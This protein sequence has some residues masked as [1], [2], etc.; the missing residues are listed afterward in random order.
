MRPEEP[1]SAKAV[2]AVL[3]AGFVAGTS[4]LLVTG[5]QLLTASTGT[6]EEEASRGEQKSSDVAYHFAMESA[7]EPVSGAQ[8]TQTVQTPLAMLE[9]DE[10]IRITSE[11]Q[12]AEW[13]QLQEDFVRAV[14]GR[15]P[16]NETEREA[17]IRAQQEND[18]LFR[19]KFGWDAFQQQQL[20]AHRE[21]LAPAPPP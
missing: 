8:D 16:S 1:K 4:I 18:E 15:A 12:V 14:D 7:Q 20:K 5:N 11:L 2:W 17:W 13:E 6:N 9:P 21:G 3:A 19:V 10:S